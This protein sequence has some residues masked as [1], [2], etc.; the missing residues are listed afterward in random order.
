[1]SVSKMLHE[2][3]R[4]IRRPALTPAKYRR[5]TANQPDIKIET[6]DKFEFNI[7][8]GVELNERTITK[9]IK[10]ALKRERQN[11]AR[12]IIDQFGGTK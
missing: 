3:D 6:H 4:I 8:T 11:M 1:I 9:M 2:L 10:N 12:Q 5:T 7:G